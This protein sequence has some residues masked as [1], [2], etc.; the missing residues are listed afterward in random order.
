MRD[1]PE[2]VDLLIAV[3]K[4]ISNMSQIY[5]EQDARD[6]YREKEVTKLSMELLLQIAQIDNERVIIEVL[7]TFI[8]MVS[9]N[10]EH[11]HM[12]KHLINK[13]CLL[14]IVDEAQMDPLV[15]RILERVSAS[16]KNYHTSEP[17]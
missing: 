5:W 4:L 12:M 3:L 14:D 16:M 17:V 9:I 10:P 2:K 7:R 8:K 15:T 13:K 1:F 11:H 6:L